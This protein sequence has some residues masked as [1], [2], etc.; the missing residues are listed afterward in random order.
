MTPS[1]STTA[2][3]TEPMVSP[4]RCA[5]KRAM[6]SEARRRREL[7]ESAERVRR[8]LAAASILTGD[9]WAGGQLAEATRFL[10]ASLDALDEIAER[11]GQ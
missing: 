11:L 6:T 3:M 2:T 7:R 5:L 9:S 8:D 1:K 10:S 4:P